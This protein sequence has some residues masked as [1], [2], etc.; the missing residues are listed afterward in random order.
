MVAHLSALPTLVRAVRRKVGESRGRR[1]FYRKDRKDHRESHPRSA[2]AL[3][4]E[5]R[6]ALRGGKLADEGIRAP[7]FPTPA[8]FRHFQLD[9][10]ASLCDFTIGAL[11]AL[12]CINF[13]KN[14]ISHPLQFGLL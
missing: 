11:K 3:I 2:D 13:M 10:P 7:L 12:T 5:V 9:G 6:V 8:P 4:R 14:L 1:H